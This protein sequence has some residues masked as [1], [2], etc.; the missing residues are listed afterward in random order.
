MSIEPAASPEHATPLMAPAPPAR[1]VDPVDVL[2]GAVM[3]LMVID[4]TRDFFGNAAIDLTDLSRA[5]PALFL[6][7]WV[8]HF[9]APVFAFLAGAGAYLAG[10]RGRSRGDL[11]VF[12]ASRGVWLI[13]LELA[14]VRL[15]LFFDPVN[16]PV[17]LTVL[18]SIGASFVVLAGLVCLPSRVV[19][20]LG[21]LLI[22]THGLADSLSP[23]SETPAVLRTASALLLRPG[24]LPLPGSVVVIVGYPLLPWL[25]IVA[26][27]YGFGEVI[28]LEPWRR[29]RVMWITGVAM[30]AAFVILRTWGVYGEPRPWTTQATPVLTGLSFVNCTKQP[31]SLLFVLMTLGPAITAL[32][33]IDRV[34]IRGPVGRPFVTLGRVPLFYY[35]LQWYVIHGLA[36]LA[37]LVRGLPV[38][39]LFSPEALA[40]PPDGWEL[41]LPG[42]Y[43]AWAVVLVVLYIPCRWFAGVKARHPGGWLTYL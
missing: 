41:D 26:A 24:L 2:R 20:A 17:I 3:I 12:L 6:T 4:H 39:W 11:A 33:V 32:A 43:A 19:G 35:L 15:G 27:G 34:D 10:S 40:P 7:R 28:R 22:V 9:C 37:G 5:S 29:R 30:T 1:R 16:A 13:F 42:I 23:G 36:V 21:V 31:P 8:T 25:G 38:A 14:V 18:W